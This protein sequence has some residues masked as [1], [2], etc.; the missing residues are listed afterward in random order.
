ML[1]ELNLEE[2]PELI[3]RLVYLIGFEMVN[4]EEMLIILLYNLW[5][6][7]NSVDHQDDASLLE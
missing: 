3:S 7:D 2:I 1:V 5:L 6:Y 4:C